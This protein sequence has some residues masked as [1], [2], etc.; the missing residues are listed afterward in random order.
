MTEVQ[1]LTGSLRTS[2]EQ[3][4]AWQGSPG[5]TPSAAGAP[6]AERPRRERPPHLGELVNEAL[7]LGE[8]HFEEVDLSL[9]LTLVQV[10]QGA[11]PADDAGSL[12]L[13]RRHGTVGGHGVPLFG[14]PGLGCLRHP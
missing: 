5:H 14:L 13:Q 9:I 3:R 4:V 6:T 7:L 2:R 10:V 1:E 11:G 12:P 8:L